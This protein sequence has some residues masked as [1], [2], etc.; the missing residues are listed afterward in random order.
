MEDHQ[1]VLFVL[2][3]DLNF[4]MQVTFSDD[5]LFEE[6]LAVRFS[7]RLAQSIGH[8]LVHLDDARVGQVDARDVDG[9][10]LGNKLII[11]CC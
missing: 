8:L 3:I 10:D 1:S 5:G 6:H 7:H 2:E 4:Q 11:F 9:D